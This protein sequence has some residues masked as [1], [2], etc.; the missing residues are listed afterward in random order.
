MKLRKRLKVK[1]RRVK[2]ESAFVDFDD[3]LTVQIPLFQHRL[4]D[5]EFDAATALG[6]LAKSALHYDAQRKGLDPDE[7]IEVKVFANNHGTTL[8]DW[9]KQQPGTLVDDHQ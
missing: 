9:V 2:V 7:V 1:A 4:E 3:G 6:E 5:P 8:I